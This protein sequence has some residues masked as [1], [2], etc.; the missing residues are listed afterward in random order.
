[1]TESLTNLIEDRFVKYMYEKRLQDVAR[2]ADMWHHDK[3]K[4]KRFEEALDVLVS[5]HLSLRLRFPVLLPAD[6]PEDDQIPTGPVR[7]TTFDLGEA[8]DVAVLSTV[9]RE[10]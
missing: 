3:D 8:G 4:A 2:L 1:M 7:I 5:T 6:M 10:T 9:P